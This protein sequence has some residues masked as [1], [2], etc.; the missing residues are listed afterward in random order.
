MKEIVEKNQCSGCAG[1]ANICPQNAIIIK[2]DVNGFYRPF[3]DAEKCTDCGLCKKVCPSINYTETNNKQPEVYAIMSEDNIRKESSSGGAFT[4]IA[5]WVLSKGGYVAGAAYNNDWQVE[6]IIIN[7]QE[8]L[9]KI[10]GSKYVQSRISETLYKDIK[11]L[12]EDEKYVLFSGCPCQTAGLKYFLRKDYEK[13][14]LIDIY[15]TYAPSPKMYRKFLQ[16]TGNNIENVNFRDKELAGWSCSS[17]V[18]TQNNQ[19]QKFSEYMKI[20]HSKLAMSETCE[21]CKYATLPRQS[22][23][24]LADFWG[25][26][27]FDKKLDDKLGTSIYMI[28]SAKGKYVLSQ[29]KKE[30]IKK[31]KQVPLKYAMQRA[32]EKPFKSH[33]LRSKF[34][35][36]LE[37]HTFAEAYE[38][39]LGKQNNIGIMNFWYV[40]NRGAILTNYAINEF[41]KEQGYNPKTINYYPR[42]E[43]RLHKNSI[44]EKFEKKY[45]DTTAFCEDY[46]ALKNL[47]RE[48][49]TF[50]VG[51]D[52][53]FRDWCV[54][55]HRDKYFLNFADNDAKKISCSASFGIPFYD[56][57]ETNKTIMQKYLSRFDALSVRETS[58]VEI[59]KNTFNLESTQ[60]WDPVFYIDKSKYEQIADTSKKKESKFLAY[61][62]ITMTPEK[63]KAIDFAAT[64]LGL[65]PV[66]MK[67]KLPVEDWL[68]YIKNCEYYIGDSFHGTCFALMFRKNFL[69]I[70]PRTG[71]NDTRLDTLL[72]TVNMRNRQIQ[73]AKEVYSREDLLAGIDYS[74]KFDKMNSEI[75]RSKKWL[76]DAIEAPKQEKPVTN[77]D[78]LFFATMD[79][80]NIE[81]SE[82]QRRQV[83]INNRGKI[84]L[85]YLKYGILRK[86]IFNKKHRE[87]YKKK[88][89]NLSIKM[90]ELK[91]LDI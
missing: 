26:K 19:K 82:N 8:D 61:Y 53:V 55:H 77:E 47:N 69:V 86:L 23:I 43:K 44:S 58:G 41:L 17:I 52:Q 73:S 9:N 15:C 62:I 32:C 80:L 35:S 63:R 50:L 14:L 11:N 56:G 16:E 74:D 27:K 79:R 90:R 76:I 10:R 12:L 5:E 7:N 91:S 70:S 67:G 78:K 31:L 28:N 20:Y 59:L 39:T 21:N 89:K 2:E 64:K 3:I 30:K 40:P 33:R 25:I 48:I 88:Y 24:T 18:L 22:D 13:L 38:K 4:L 83:L 60:I 57:S 84:Y 37:N 46:I 85:N 49:G 29:L 65:K 54:H 34:Y 1:C 81:S 71:E 72:E 51:S 45:L 75:E 6:H 87:H 66:D 68:Y 42:I 36:L